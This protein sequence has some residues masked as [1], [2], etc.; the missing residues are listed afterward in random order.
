M[1]DAV[2]PPEALPYLPLFMDLPA[3][4]AWCWAQAKRRPT[5]RLC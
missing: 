5:R 1:S 3:G 4:P 2:K